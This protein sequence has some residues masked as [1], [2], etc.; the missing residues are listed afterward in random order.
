MAESITDPAG[1]A[2]QVNPRNPS[3]W[4]EICDGE[5]QNY[6]YR[7][8]GVLAQS[9]WSQANGKFTVPTGQTQN[10]F[11]SS[12]RVL[13]VNGDQHANHDDVIT[14]DV[15][16]GGVRVTLNSETAQFESGAISSI[17]VNSGDGNDTINVWR[18]LAGVPTT[19]TSRGA[20]FVNLGTAGSVQ[21]ILGNVTITD[22]VGHNDQIDINDTND[23]GF[24]TV[25]VDTFTPSGDT[26]HERIGGL[27]PGV[28]DFRGAD[29][30]FLSVETGRGGATINVLGTAN[31][32][33][34]LENASGAVN[35]G[36]AG[37]LQGIHGAVEIRNI[38]GGSSRTSVTVD[39]SAD[40]AARAGSHATFGAYGQVS[41]LAPANIFY[42]YAET[43]SAT[44]K[45]GTSTTLNVLGTLAP[46]TVIAG[47]SSVVN[48]GNSS[49][50]LDSLLGPLTVNGQAGH[51]VLNLLDQGTTAAKTYTIS[52][53]SVARSGG[54]T[55]GYAS[56]G[57]LTLGG[58]SGGNTFNVE[59]TAAATTTTISA[60]SGTNTISLS[61]TAHNL[62][63]LAGLVAIHGQGGTALNLN[64]QSTTSRQ[65]YNI[66]D[67]RIDWAPY[68]STFVTHVQYD[69]L[70]NL[71]LNGANGPG[72]SLGVSRTAAGTTTVVN[73]NGGSDS[74]L[75]WEDGPGILDGMRGP[76]QMHSQGASN[77]LELYD[78]GNTTGHTYR[79]S[80]V[81]A[82]NRLELF[83]VQG[84]PDL[85]PITWDGQGAET[86]YT[87]SQTANVINVVGNSPGI[88]TQLT[89]NASD[90]VNIG[91]G[92]LSAVQDEVIVTGSG[93]IQVNVDDSAD[94]T[95][96]QATFQTDYVFP[97]LT[98]LA[99][100]GIYFNL[101]PAASVSVLGGSGGNMF[102]MDGAASFALSIN[103]GIGANTLDYS[104]Y[105]GNVI[106]DLQTGF[107]T[108]IAG[109][110]SGNFVSVYG[111]NSS[112]AGLYNLLIG[113]GGNVLTGG[114]G[115]R[116]ILVAGGAAS[117]LNG[118]TQ[119]DLLIGGTTAY[120]TEAGLV[121]WQAIA[122]Y[123]AG[124]DD[125]NTRVNNLETGNGAPLLDATTV[126]G[127]GGGN[128]M[129]G[130]GE[131]ALIYTDGNDTI[132]GFDPG[133]QLYPITP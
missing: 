112:G 39:D 104:G 97:Y 122:A 68:G 114:T 53:S 65:Q 55:I 82:T 34:L 78:G 88:V 128:T 41:G 123:W 45:A 19:I 70:T 96:R 69:G 121:S 98:G 21:G 120:D 2:L 43:A 11:V 133:S 40:S 91:Q 62:A 75:V 3:S 57:S 59:S 8:G 99:P 22:P 116:N 46:L 110:L 6:S 1:D 107:A 86:L 74:F 117:T 113:A 81:G 26:A 80:A 131:L 105:S 124:T 42:T 66:F 115:R 118:G 37:S 67:S 51:G 31:Y 72:N 129:N 102:R 24:H 93:A 30:T 9:Y 109:G 49:N 12:G 106:V 76:L 50:Q 28:I 60:G 132:T 44:I 108:G 125:D 35:V 83:D 29:T 52:S 64:D 101:D 23:L 54:P 71:T 79:L 36:N 100:A 90:T 17:V 10:F 7:L 111:A 126:T 103:G 61:P 38:G 77:T 119:D 4:N 85:A 92:D 48:V 13:T 95:P 20:A 87:P 84:N 15:S 127:N 18:T 14:L 27:A 32:T 89:A 73:G 56:L 47:G 58:G 130:L 33:D 63:N 25:T 5:A 94:P 16:G